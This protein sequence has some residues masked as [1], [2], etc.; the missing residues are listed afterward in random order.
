MRQFD[1][2]DWLNERLAEAGQ[3]HPVHE[4]GNFCQLL[5]LAFLAEFTLG[6]PEIKTHV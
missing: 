6:E 1:D 2:C 3:H 5:L 4:G